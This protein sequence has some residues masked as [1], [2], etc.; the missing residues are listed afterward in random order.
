MPTWLGWGNQRFKDYLFSI[1]QITGIGLAIHRKL[2]GWGWGL[3]CLWRGTG[4]RFVPLHYTTLHTASELDFV[5]F[6]WE[7]QGMKLPLG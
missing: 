6:G 4:E 7:E 1:G 2:S 3:F 5:Q